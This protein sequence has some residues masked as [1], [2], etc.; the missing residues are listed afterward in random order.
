MK[1]S[2]EIIKEGFIKL[3]ETPGLFRK[4]HAKFDLFLQQIEF[5]W[6]EV[7]DVLNNTEINY[8]MEIGTYGGG[9][10]LTLCEVANDNATLISMDL[11]AKPYNDPELKKQA[12]KS[13]G[14][15]NQIIHI[16]KG[17]SHEIQAIQWTNGTLQD[18]KLD[19]LFID[20]DHS[21]EGVKKDFNDYSPFVKKGGIIMFH[22]I[23]EGKGA[24]VNQLWD[25]IKSEYASK[26][27]IENRS[28]GWAGIGII[29][30]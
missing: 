17:D 28:Q 2:F 5:E 13:M 23:L 22:D 30:K 25:E 7:I 9:S 16:Y 21:Y 4:G 8:G 12:L 6:S 19:Y 29:W 11:W 3:K 15:D 14:K 18:N 27:I 20:G 24:A 10:F 1:C 26:E